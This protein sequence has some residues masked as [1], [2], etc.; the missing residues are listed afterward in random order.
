MLWEKMRHPEK[1]GES[2]GLADRKNGR[3]GDA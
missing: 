2:K 3:T 1:E